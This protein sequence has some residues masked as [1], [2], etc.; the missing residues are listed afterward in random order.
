MLGMGQPKEILQIL[1]INR[2][3]EFGCPNSMISENQFRI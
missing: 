3:L 2:E 1:F